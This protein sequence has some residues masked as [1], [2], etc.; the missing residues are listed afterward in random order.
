MRVNYISC[1]GSD[2]VNS[3]LWEGDQVSTESLSP[4]CQTIVVVLP[5]C[6]MAPK[7]QKQLGKE[8]SSEPVAIV[9]LDLKQHF[10]CWQCHKDTDSSEETEYMSSGDHTPPEMT[11]PRDWGIDPN[12][13]YKQRKRRPGHVYSPRQVSEEA[14]SDTKDTPTSTSMGS[15]RWLAARLDGHLCKRPRPDEEPR[16]EDKPAKQSCPF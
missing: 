5:L 13:K 2:V 6:A 12:R 3:I 7:S 8:T 10:K 9:K 15:E 4:L 14:D 16:V 1:S 11:D